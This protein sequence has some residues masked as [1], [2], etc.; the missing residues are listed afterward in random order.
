MSSFLEAIGIS[1]VRGSANAL[2]NVD[3]TVEKGELLTILGP[4]GSGKTS[5]L[6]VL[7]GF[8]TPQRADRLRIDGEDMLKQPPHRRP[9]ATVFQHYALFPHLPVGA[10]VE[11]GLRVRKVSREQRR[12]RAQ[13]ALALLHLEG[14]YDRRIDELSGG[15][16]QRVAFARAL[17]TEPKILLLD[18]P[19]GAL[20]EHLRKALE[21]EIRTLQR[22]LGMTVIQVTHGRE[23]A[24][25][26]SD[27]VVVMNRGRVVQTGAPRDIFDRPATKFVADFMGLTNVLLGSVVLGAAPDA[28]SL[29]TDG[30]RFDGIWSGSAPPS[31]GQPAFLAVHPERLRR[32]I[33]CSGNSLTGRLRGMTYAG[34]GWMVDLETPAGQISATISRHDASEDIMTFTWTPEDGPIGPVDVA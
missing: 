21:Q 29:Q 7:G 18:E 27:R 20:D 3:L 26:M 17:V 15:E 31:Q 34:V 33:T 1:L 12:A 10:N 23:E 8:E 2:E 11:Y 6:R 14:K 9:V 13:Q 24:L 16:R 22:D 5:L 25:S 19:M 32:T 30:G 4:S 28:V